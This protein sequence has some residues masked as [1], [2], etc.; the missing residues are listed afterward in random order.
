MKIKGITANYFITVQNTPVPFKSSQSYPADKVE[1]SKDVVLNCGL[2]KLKN[3]NKAEYY[4]LTE[5]EKTA[6]R[7]KLQNRE[8]TELNENVK[9]EVK[10][11]Q[12]AAEAIKTV[13]DKQF[14]E[15][16]YVVIPI[17][18]SLSSVG[19]ALAIRIGE[20]NVKNIPMSNMMQYCSN[21]DNYDSYKFK[22]N[23]FNNNK[24][25]ED[26]KEYLTSIGLSREEVNKSG[27]QYIIIDY[28]SSGA[29]LDAAYTILTSDDFLGNEKHNISTAPIYSIT[30]SIKDDE[31][32]RYLLG[33]FQ[34]FQ[35]YSF[36]SHANC[37]FSDMETKTNFNKFS[38][39]QK[40]LITHKLFGFALLDGEF[41]GNEKISS[42]EFKESL[43]PT[44][45]ENIP[46][47]AQKKFVWNTTNEQYRYDVE[48]D[49]QELYNL[50]RRIERPIYKLNKKTDNYQ[51]T[52]R[53]KT[54][55]LNYD[56]EKKIKAKF[57][58]E[59]EYFENQRRF[60]KLEKELPERILKKYKPVIY[61]ETADFGKD[62]EVYKFIENF[63]K[64]SD[65]IH[66][67]INTISKKAKIFKIKKAQ[68]MLRKL[69]SEMSEYK[70]QNKDEKKSFEVR[71]KYY[72]KFR[73]NLKRILMAVTKQFPYEF[74]REYPD[75]IDSLYEN[76]FK[77][78]EEKNMTFA[79]E[80]QKKLDSMTVCL[81]SQEIANLVNLQK[82][83]LDDMCNSMFPF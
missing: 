50:M 13:F 40:E 16:N 8:G 61:Q 72:N 15:G 56:I 28:T 83:A 52:L 42:L 48:K 41:S 64:T 54:T 31:D 26:Y 47:P 53:N 20:E 36:V 46:N 60:E 35:K 19:K 33:D 21:G 55:Y 51:N 32:N 73:P 65:S 1:F 69:D 79:S 3:I 30:G 34:E 58:L 29:S 18:R 45:E 71:E 5:A 39:D 78:I 11:H 6:L 43:E 59:F 14:G 82:K 12:F 75:K 44:W 62:S 70:L 24:G 49:A 37:D 68:Y 17:G 23:Q 81:P 80:T 67:E 63:V 66:S 7:R 77:D 9:D 76:E 27:K 57:P 38:Y 4:S 2:A 74:C 10:G 25:I 22:L